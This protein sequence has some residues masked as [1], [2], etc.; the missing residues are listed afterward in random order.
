MLDR[1]KMPEQDPKVR[2]SNFN[3]VALGFTDEQAIEEAKR[4]LQCK[5]PKCIE[6]LPC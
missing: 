2:R 5:K 6:G 4:C 1:Q 3:E